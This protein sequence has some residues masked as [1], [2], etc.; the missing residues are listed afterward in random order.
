MTIYIAFLRGI[1]VGGHNK[2][3]MQE[4]RNLLTN[5]GLDKVNTYI[6]SGNIVFQSDENAEQLQHQIEQEIRNYFGFSVTVILRTVTELEQIINN[7][8]YPVNLLLEGE[9]V[10]LSLLAKEP[11]K[12]GINHLLDLKSEMEECYIK[13][14]EVYLYLRQGVRNSK[15][16]SQLQKLGVPA[17]ARNWKTIKKL[18]T[19]VKAMK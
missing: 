1:N 10:H 14:K 17:T 18:E 8:P 5:M 13:G 9:S 16:S 7:C 6:Q 2:I 19:M 4:L 11:S 3:K 15:L 12:E